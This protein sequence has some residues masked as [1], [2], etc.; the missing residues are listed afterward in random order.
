[1]LFVYL[2]QIYSK[3]I[4]DYVPWL[5]SILRVY[6]F[7]GLKK[8]LSMKK[9]VQ[10]FISLQREKYPWGFFIEKR[11]YTRVDYA[12]KL[13][14]QWSTDFGGTLIYENF[15]HYRKTYKAFFT[16]MNF[17][18][19]N[20]LQIALAYNENPNSICLSIQKLFKKQ[21]RTSFFKIRRY[22]HSTTFHETDLADDLQVI[23]HYKTL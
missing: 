3:T 7:Q 6:Q 20:V 4:V 14:F 23:C 21:W 9:T 16:L 11:V 17:I 5:N 19:I 2:K 10:G 13:I 8:R 1:M 12:D 22:I 15:F 18:W